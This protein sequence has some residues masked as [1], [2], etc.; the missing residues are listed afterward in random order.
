[1]NANGPVLNC[2]VE[3]HYRRRVHRGKNARPWVSGEGPSGRPET[4]SQH[5]RDISGAPAGGKSRGAVR[6]CGWHIKRRASGDAEIGSEASAGQA[7]RHVHRTLGCRLGQPK[8]RPGRRATAGCTGCLGDLCVSACS[9]PISQQRSA[10]ARPISPGPAAAALP[11]ITMLPWR[12][13]SACMTM[14]WRTNC[15]GLAWRSRSNDAILIEMNTVRALDSAHRAQCV[16][17]LRATGMHLGLLMKF[18]TPRL[19]VRRVVLDL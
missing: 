8:G 1:M 10:P 7:I 4:G 18:G 2:F 14:R 12:S 5:D 15:V 3:A 6:V 17:H 16:N 11:S 9:A 13:E 19:E